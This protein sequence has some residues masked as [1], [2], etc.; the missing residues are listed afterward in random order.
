MPPPGTI[1]PGIVLKV[2]AADG[3]TK[4]YVNVCG[5]DSVGLPL[6]KS[7]DTIPDAA[8]MDHHGLDNLII[9][10][11]VG[12]AQHYNRTSDVDG[13]KMIIVDVV[14]HSQIVTRVLPTHSRYEAFLPKVSAL[15]LDWVTQ[16]TG[17]QLLKKTCKMVSGT[18]Y[19]DPPAKKIKGEGGADDN[20][21]PAERRQLEENIRNRANSLYEQLLKE[22]SGKAP[23]GAPTGP[24][25]SSS[26]AT[27][28]DA[29]KLPT[30]SGSQK[31][32]APKK[33]VQEMPIPS[34]E[35]VIRKGFLNNPGKR[36]Y[37]DKGSTEGVLPEG[38]GDPLGYLPKGLRNRVQVI[39]TRP[40]AQPKPKPSLPFT[41]GSADEVTGADFLEQLS[42][43]EKVA[44][45]RDPNAMEAMTQML[46]NE[47]LK[48]NDTTTATT[49]SSSAAVGSSASNSNGP[50]V[51]TVKS[52]SSVAPPVVSS[53]WT[54]VV[55]VD[56]DQCP[57]MITIRL[58]APD[59]IVG[60][61]DVDLA[62]EPEYIDVN[63]H[64]V[65]LPC[66]LDVDSI[67]AKF[68]KSTRTLVI[69]GNAQ[70]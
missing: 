26:G 56:N 62:A 59:S 33:L 25:V 50:T 6:T 29:F 13:G 19:K 48:Q 22:T 34:S 53:G 58:A 69:T 10:I 67:K 12:D 70:Q 47:L 44:S 3:A 64:R 5:H 49:S 30:P 60:M 24:A 23:P 31:T 1:I 66:K 11:S 20:L 65:I 51:P 57:P 55:S 46:Q 28:P 18:S 42:V 45:N 38:A 68:V 17:I 14:I 37:D 16:E 9:P 63:E 15:A 39:D 61:K 36:L 43:F 7:M 4:V 52:S 40:E 8:F 32:E 35:P 21:S 41:V 54:E 27:L 2:L